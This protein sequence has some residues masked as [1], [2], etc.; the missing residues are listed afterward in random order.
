MGPLSAAFRKVKEVVRRRRCVLSG[1]GAGF[2]R[3]SL[4]FFRFRCSDFKSQFFGVGADIETPAESLRQSTNDNEI[5]S[6]SSLSE[7]GLFWIMRISE[8]KI[9]FI[10]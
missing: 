6:T 3:T 2:L 1:L 5:D 8:H 4:I 7:T 9:S 10:Q